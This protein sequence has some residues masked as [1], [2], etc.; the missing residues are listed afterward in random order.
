MQMGVV[1]QGLDCQYLGV[2]VLQGF[3]YLLLVVRDVNTA[4]NVQGG[5]CPPLRSS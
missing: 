1:M 4:F 2:Y 3:L 5:T